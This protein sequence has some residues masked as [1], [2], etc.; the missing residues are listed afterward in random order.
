MLEPGNWINETFPFCDWCL[1]RWLESSIFDADMFG[2]AM[3]SPDNDYQVT[4]GRFGGIRTI[5]DPEYTLLDNGID[6]GYH[7]NAYGYLSPTY[8]Y[9][10]TATSKQTFG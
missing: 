2:R 5:Y 4:E 1:G 3:G 8:N 9:Q 7:Y 6:I 10:V